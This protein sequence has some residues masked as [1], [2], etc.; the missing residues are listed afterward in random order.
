MKYLY[1][2]LF[3]AFLL[4]ILSCTGGVDSNPPSLVVVLCDVSNSVSASGNTSNIKNVTSIAQ[5]LLTCFPAKSRLIYLPISENRY[6]KHLIDFEVKTIN[7]ATLEDEKARI[8]QGSSELQKQLNYLSTSKADSYNTCILTS[9]ENAYNIL[10]TH[11][12]RDAYKDHRYRLIILSD[13][14]ESC[15]SSPAGAVRMKVD[16]MKSMDQAA[17]LLGKFEP[18]INLDQSKI[19]LLVTMTTPGLTADVSNKLEAIWRQVF[20]KMGYGQAAEL[21]FSQDIPFTPR[22]ELQPD[23]V[24]TGKLSSATLDMDISLPVAASPVCTTSHGS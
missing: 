20:E 6:A 22:P 11:A 15:T 21:R 5:K 12:K 17:S 10:V 16:N 3:T 1:Q 23:S 4:L 13:L 18:K 24:Q 7:D 2:I 9:I 19:D 14:L 8:K